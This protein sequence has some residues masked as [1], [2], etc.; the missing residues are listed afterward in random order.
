MWNYKELIAFA[1]AFVAFVLP[2]LENIKEIILFGSVVRWE[3][4][5]SSDI[6]LFFNIENKR[7]EEAIKRTIKKE[8]S[9]FYV[10]KMA[11]TFLFKG[12]RSKIKVNIG[13]LEEWELKRS[14]ISDGIV[15]YGKYKETP[16]NLKGFV[17]FNINPVKDIA[18]RNKLIRKLFGR[19]EKNY[20]TKGV[21]ENINGKKLS[22]SSFYVPLEN[23]N[24]IIKI[25]NEE[26][27]NYIFFE[28]WKD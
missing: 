5:K 24:Q 6:D 4:D 13:N 15:L 21:L 20:S 11:E 25:L 3:A 19:K 27:I 7:D 9:R 2:K 17:L 22:P 16:Q 8:L 14:I 1:S 26:K 12:I 28:F 10:S 23:T 18:R